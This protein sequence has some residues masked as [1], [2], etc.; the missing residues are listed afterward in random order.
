VTS[1]SKARQDLFDCFDYSLADHPPNAYRVRER[2][3]K[4]VASLSEMPTGRTGR[5]F[6]T[7][8]AYVPLTSMIICHEVPDK[9]TLQVLRLINAKRS[10][11]EGEWPE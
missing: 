1:A 7:F 11:P 5:V 6:G 3:L 9:D 2:I 10:W 4:R 8:E